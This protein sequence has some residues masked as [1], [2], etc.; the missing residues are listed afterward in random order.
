LEGQTDGQTDGQ[1][2]RPLRPTTRLIFRQNVVNLP[3]GKAIRFSK[4]F[5]RLHLSAQSH[6]IVVFRLH[7][8]AL[9]TVY[10]VQ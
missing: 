9:C 3:E 7:T 6:K 2:S 4:S 1:A 10:S 5:Q 8:L